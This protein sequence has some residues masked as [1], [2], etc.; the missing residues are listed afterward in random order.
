[1]IVDLS[2]IYVS[3]QTP[4]LLVIDKIF[5]ALELCYYDIVFF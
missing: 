1:M 4:S 2:K 3:N 5:P